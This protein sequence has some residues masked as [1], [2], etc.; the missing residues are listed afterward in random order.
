MQVK[1]PAML[2]ADVEGRPM[3]DEV[4][5]PDAV[6]RAASVQAALVM[7]TQF[8]ES[9]EVFMSD[10]VELAAYIDSPPQQ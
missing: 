3:L 10:V 1:I 4:L 6:H 5:K 2:S 8:S 9:G 7:L